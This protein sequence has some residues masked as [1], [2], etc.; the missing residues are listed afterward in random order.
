[1]CGVIAYRAGVSQGQMHYHLGAMETKEVFSN[2]M[3]LNIS[4][5]E[6]IE[7]NQLG[8]ERGRCRPVFSIDSHFRRTKSDYETGP[9]DRWSG[10]GGFGDIVRQ[11]I[12]GLDKRMRLPSAYQ[13]SLDDA[14][15][16]PPYHINVSTASELQYSF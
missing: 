2:V 4:E 10:K 7:I 11:V 13:S 14:N 5:L 3:R 1:M 15:P 9:K 6:K 8:L 16:P 12:S